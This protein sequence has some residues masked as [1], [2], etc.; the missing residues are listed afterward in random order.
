[1]FKKIKGD[2]LCSN[3]IQRYQ[4]FSNQ[5]GIILNHPFGLGGN[6]EFLTL[7][8]TVLTDYLNEQITKEKMV[9]TFD[10]ILQ[11]MEMEDQ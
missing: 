6:T 11:M 7:I 4:N 3:V 2:S 5:W 9:K 10:Q 8:T 1:M